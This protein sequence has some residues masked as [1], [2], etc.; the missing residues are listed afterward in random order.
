MKRVYSILFL[1]IILV[2]FIAPTFA[3]QQI[4]SSENCQIKYDSLLTAAE[5]LYYTDA[6]G[7]LEAAQHLLKLAKSCK[8]ANIL[9]SAHQSLSWAYLILS[10][11]PEAINN[12]NK[13][14]QIA[15]NN[16]KNSQL[17]DAYN[18]LGNVYLEVP[19]KDFALKYFNKG[20]DLT[21]SIN[22]EGSLITFYHNIAVAYE[23]FED[24][25]SSLLFYTKAK[26]YYEK[27]GKK[28]DKGAIYINIGDLYQQLSLADSADK[29]HKMARENLVLNEDNDYLSILFSSIA[30]KEAEK[31]N[32][33]KALLYLDSCFSTLGGGHAVTDYINFYK[34]RSEILHQKGNYLSAYSDLL[35][36]YDLKDSILSK[37]VYNKLRDVQ[38]SAIEA[39][40]E[41]EIQ[42]LQQEK[43]I[44]NLKLS[45]NKAV[46]KNFILLSVTTTSAMLF[47]IFIVLGNRRNN[48]KLR[49]R[50]SIIE[51]Q[52][53]D[54]L[55]KN[56][57]LEQ[58]NKE[59]IDSINYAKRIQA[60]ILPPENS[61]KK[62]FPES[63]V[64][65]K[66]KNIVAG[67]FYWLNY[68]PNKG[69]VIYF[70]AA[71][72]TGHGVPGAM[73]SV[74]CNNALNRSLREYD[75]TDPGKILDKTRDI[76]IQEFEKASEDVKD[77]MDIA[78]VGLK[79]NVQCS[80]L[81][82]ESVAELAYS[83]ANN[84]LWIIRPCHS[85]RI[86]ES[87]D[88]SFVSMT[89]YELLEVKPDKQPI[90][91]YTNPKPF[92]THSIDL[93]KGDSIYLFTDGYQDQFGGEKGKK[94]K[95]LALKKLLLSI[96][97]K[98]MEEQCRIL[99]ETFEAWRDNLEQVDDVCV[100]GVR[101]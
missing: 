36:A 91:K 55:N 73:V 49:D 61:F 31:R 62:H 74:I 15:L 9:F 94:F 43:R 32:Y 83:G 45:E 90:G 16:K 18:L 59:I 56:L 26:E 82:S 47:L 39:Q 69:E 10:N 7:S 19:D 4:K 100:I 11:F 99:N 71:D 75:I 21:S 92:K 42:S 28:R 85:G 8:D 50:N 41:A 6:K 20:I 14:L 97:D 95:K 84:P 12:A 2:I 65:Y 53:I 86:E 58:F 57:Q 24:L 63:F 89:D 54:I 33:P 70:A 98:S 101:V 3:Q 22:E 68:S 77:G 29:Y 48:K 66:P 51:T 88:A 35:Q 87:I 23:Q 96:Q 25:E 76:V 64:L 80:M 37:E 1:K 27:S 72:C 30:T 34:T 44:Q 17:I 5:E 60:A 78:L 93:Q 38:I 79:F 52:S 67:D 13:A 46:Q 40:K 81:N